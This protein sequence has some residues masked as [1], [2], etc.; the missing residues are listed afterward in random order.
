MAKVTL[1]LGSN[2]GD[3][4]ANIADAIARLD[5]SGVRVIRR[6][7]EYR[8]DPWGPIEQDWFV[9]ACVAGETELPPDA[10][11]QLCLSI[12]QALGRTR[13]VRW[14]PRT[15]DIDILT[16]GNLTLHNSRLAIPH[17]HMLERAFVLLPLAEIEPDLIVS[18]CRVAEAADRLSSDG[19]VKLSS[20]EHEGPCR[21]HS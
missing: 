2:L 16:Y 18:G 14:G 1:G 9:N 15:I 11:L 5:Q 7:S 8:T 17:P 6:S 3:K 21:K 13:E 4:R 20:P 19:V 10:L 12:E